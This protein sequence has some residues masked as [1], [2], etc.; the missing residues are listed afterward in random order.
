ML[1]KMKNLNQR[2]YELFKK[3]DLK[4]CNKAICSLRLDGEDFLK[5]YSSWMKTLRMASL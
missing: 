3:E 1:R 2:L 4:S 5:K